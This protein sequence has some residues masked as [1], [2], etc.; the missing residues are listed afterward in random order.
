M[1][2]NLIKQRL[3]NKWLLVIQEY[4]LVKQR[5]SKN[6][7]TVEDICSAYKVHRKDIRKYYERWIKAGRNTDSLLP[8][9]AGPK[10][11]TLKILT[12][13][14]E[15]SIVAIRRKLNA[16]EFEIHHMIKG[17]FR[18]HPSVSTIY[19]TFKRYP[20][21]KARKEKIKR[22]EKMYP[23]EQAHTDTHML[24][25]TLFIDRQRQHLFGLLDDCTR[26][27]YVELIPNIQSATVTQAFARGYKWFSAHGIKIEEVLSD[28][29]S[30][31][32]TFTGSKRAK[33][34][35]VF[36]SMLTIFDIKH[37]YIRPYRP[38]TNGKIERFWKTLY[39]ECTRLQTVSQ[40]KEEFSAELEGYM[41]RY[42]YQR[43]HSGIKY[44]TPLEKL[45]YVTEIMK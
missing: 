25:K 5:R 19:R 6:F 33:E 12:K 1:M 40:T 27:C 3:T 13:D 4:E 2:T 8:H 30:E 18:L 20:L 35:H 42:N 26:L 36:E 14:E 28:N 44:Q 9:K 43:L 7:N 31:F 38:Q 24:A 22:Y 10:A 17:K 34:K 39:N 21:N 15:R 37:K 41:Y 16:N 29:G 32:T 23:G 11:G 45:K